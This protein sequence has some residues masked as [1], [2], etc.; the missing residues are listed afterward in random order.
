MSK[1]G[2][3]AATLAVL[4]AVC[5]ASSAAIAQP[6]TFTTE[7]GVS[8]HYDVVGSGAQTVIIPMAV[9]L[10]EALA[11]LA[12]PDRR[13]VFYD[14]RHRGRS[15]RGALDSVS[16]D[17]Q[18]RDLDQLR[19]HLGAER[20]ALLGWSGLGME[21]A[22]YAIRH[23]NRVTRL[24]QVGAVPP[25]ASVMRSAGG[26]TRASRTDTAAVSALDR[27]YN[28]PGMA[29]S[30][31]NYCT[32]RNRLT[33]PANFVDTTLMARLPDVCALEN[34]W[35]VNLWPYFGKLLGSFGDYDW[36]P[37][38]ARL[39]VPRLVIHGAQDGIP[40]A[41]SR[42]WVSGFGNARLVVLSPAGHFPFLERPAEF[43][44]AVD[45]FLRGGW[46]PGATAVPRSD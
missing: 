32:Q 36:R 2:T 1:A 10:R 44:S 42:A 22:V 14:P 25:A 11:P 31:R 21:M 29:S 30:Q 26:D 43:F 19:A 3:L 4:A 45:V 5:S 6:G 37:A 40:L 12:A 17:R 27:R 8:I 24:V 35:P 16:L 15:G 28:A 18:V 13:L 46:P 33:V 34:E 41:G 38:L 7:D 20:I 23:P 39:D 9:F